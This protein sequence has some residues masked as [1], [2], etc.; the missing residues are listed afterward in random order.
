MKCP[1][2]NKDLGEG[3]YVDIDRKGW[4]CYKC[5]I[6]IYEENCK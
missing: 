6:K 5:N 1:K 4:C 2:C 3:S